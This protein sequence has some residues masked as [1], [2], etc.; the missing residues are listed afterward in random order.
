MA[1]ARGVG[2][3]VEAVEFRGMVG[4]GGDEFFNLRDGTDAAASSCAG[5]VEGGGGAAE[6]EGADK[7]PVLQQAVDKPAWKMSPAPV[8]STTLTRKAG[9]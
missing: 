9:R 4:A 8:V 1:D 6:V 3:A 7:G 5:A 2:G